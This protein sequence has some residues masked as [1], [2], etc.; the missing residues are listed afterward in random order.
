MDIL[1][2]KIKKRNNILHLCYIPLFIQVIFSR[3]KPIARKGQRGDE[4]RRIS[5]ALLILIC[6][7]V[8]CRYMPPTTWR[9]SL[10]YLPS[11]PIRYF[12][13]TF[14]WQPLVCSSI[15]RRQEK[16]SLAVTGANIRAT[17]DSLRG[18]Y[19][20]LLTHL[21]R[22]APWNHSTNDSAVTVYT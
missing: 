6:G 11:L 21:Q 1:F 2:L 4:C 3:G 8:L 16:L 22:S 20:S 19:H 13:Y 12:D 17:I 10:Y 15:R 18:W 5:Q 14:P 7:P 9:C